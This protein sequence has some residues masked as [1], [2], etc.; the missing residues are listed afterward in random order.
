FVVG[1]G[2]FLTG[3]LS[4]SLSSRRYL[5]IALLGYTISIPIVVIGLH[6][7]QQ[8]AFSN[9]VTIKWLFVPYTV[10]QV[11][12][13]LANA[14]VVLLIVRNNLLLPVQHALAAVGRTA[15]SN[16]VLTSLLCQFVFLWGPWKLYG[17]LEY[18]QQ[19]YVVLAIWTVNI[20]FSTLW[21]RFFA[22][23]PL[24]WLWRSL[25]YWKR[26]PFLLSTRQGR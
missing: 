13:V 20:I 25:T 3:F 4:A 5:L 1:M 18:Y 12:A 7:A 8:F 2:L 9:A 10:A 26:Q 22:F 19:M 23:G 24:E 11:S 16:Y 15:F 14:S 6:R 21:L 17:T